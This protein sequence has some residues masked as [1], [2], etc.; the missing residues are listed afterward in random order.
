MGF[1]LRNCSAIRGGKAIASG[2]TGPGPIPIPIPIPIPG[3]S[4]A[5]PMGLVDR[6]PPSIDA[7]LVGSPFMDGTGDE[8]PNGFGER[9]PPSVPAAFDG[10]SLID[11][12]DEFGET[13]F[14]A[15]FS[16]GRSEDAGTDGT[17]F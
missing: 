12:N 8:L 15:E 2:E 10:N 7:G 6:P 9:P 11:G 1:M 17:V 4:D 14:D 13:G 3:I 5:D 16:M